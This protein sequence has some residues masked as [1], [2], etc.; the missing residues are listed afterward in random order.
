MNHRLFWIFTLSLVCMLM[1]WSSGDYYELKSLGKIPKNELPFFLRES[2][3]WAFQKLSGLSLEEKIAQSFM[4]AATPNKGEVHLAGID[5]L[6]ETYRIGG[7]IMF[8]GEKE[9]TKTAIERF[10][11]TSEIPL[12]IGMDAEWGSSMRLWQEKKYP[13]NLTI[14]AADD[15]ESTE[16]I[17]R[18]IAS[19]LRE[20]GV[21][22]NF[23][24]VA[25]V[26]SNPDNPVIGFRS[27]GESALKVA[28]HTRAMVLG[29]ESF[30]V[31]SCMKHFP[32]HGDT[33]VDSHHKL[34]VISKSKQELN[35][36]DWAPFK[37]G[38]L[39]GA[40]AVMM[41]HL[42]VPALD[43]SGTPSSLSKTIIKDILIDELKFSGLIIS[44][45]LNMKAVS[46]RYGKNEVVK[47]A[48]LAGNDILLYPES[49]GEA[50]SSI[51]NAV[52]KGEISLEEVD[53]KCLKILRAKY[54]AMKAD[55]KTSPLDTELL[56]YAEIK[57][58]EKALTVV[59]NEG[60]IPVKGANGKNLTLNIGVREN[61]FVQRVLTYATTDSLHAFTGSEALS[62]YGS[63]LK[64][65][66]NIFIN[67]LT[68]SV[69]PGDDY[70]YPAGW[71]ELLASLPDESNVIVTF[72]GNPYVLKK[73]HD[74]SHVDGVILAFQNSYFSRERAAQLIFG[75]FQAK[76]KLPVTLSGKYQFGYGVV[77]P[78]ATR[79]KY[80]V[81]LDVGVRKESLKRLDSIAQRGITAKA[82]PGCQII[83][84]KDG[85]VFY[86]NA[87]GYHTYDSLNPVDHETIY[88]IASITKIASST[89]SLMRLQ[90]KGLFSLNKSLGDY[91]PD[92]TE[93]TDYRNVNLRDM[94]AHQ[95]GLSPWIPFYTK[96]LVNG[97]P[98]P[99]F[100]SPTPNDSMTSRVANDLYMLGNYENV[101]YET[102]LNTSLN[103]YK[104]YKYSDLGYYFVKKIVQKQSGSSLQDFVLDNFYTP[105]GLKT[106]R[107]NPLDKFDVGR[108][109]PTEK[110]AYFRHQLVRGYVHDMGAA[111]MNGVGGH[112]GIFSNAED[113]AVLMQMLLNKGVYGGERY[114]S[115]DVIKEYT[116]CQFCPDNRRGAGFDKPVPD[117]S[118][119]PT[120]EQ[121]SLSSFGHTGFTGTQVWA[122]PQYGI[123]YVFLS[124]RVYPSSENWKIVQMN[125]RTDIQE[126]IYQLFEIKK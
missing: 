106:M 68:S 39:S 100:Y 15:I 94:M 109:A 88:D 61:G 9:N 12:L 96:T 119:G 74:F 49:I 103:R 99:M 7:V 48:Y 22:M 87:L 75:A 82:Y 66:D 91:L 90:D 123:N 40:S 80:T 105:M 93:G 104:K 43:S 126:A 37:V 102:I 4:V 23:S 81:P 18:A 50:I 110:D 34:P 112:A 21:H 59:K 36:V 84:A 76:T 46:E 31:L 1:S 28:D 115:E 116:R 54:Y 5:S 118:G 11:G 63:V 107:Y 53:A 89:I 125:I 64:D 29:L 113:L 117:K 41:A 16:V 85:K 111:M 47:L 14:G 3:D 20:L 6:I 45:A 30:N 101:L 10:Q 51:K 55:P 114:L 25:D 86:Q 27:F 121:V 33:D 57:I 17:G 73:S 78:E 69:L 60:A 13:F 19:E 56:E 79:L 77:T 71:R 42:N 8:Q 70:H 120:C 62:R 97:K 83:V 67:L 38:R 98:N 35:I 2:P 95:A 92:L 122:D 24:P 32:G 52:I 26:N 124:N 65:Y 108:I 44:D 72:F 58:Y